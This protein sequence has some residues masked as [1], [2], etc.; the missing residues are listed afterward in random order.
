VPFLPPARERSRQLRLPMA[1]GCQVSRAS[2]CSDTCG[3]SGIFL[4]SCRHARKEVLGCC[5]ENS[6]RKGSKRCG[7]SHN[8]EVETQAGENA[9]VC[10]GIPIK[11]LNRGL[12]AVREPAC[13]PDERSMQ[14]KWSHYL[15]EC[16]PIRKGGV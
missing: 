3:P 6:Q 15:V 12:Y 11:C 7:E 13:Q 1:V 16:C 10:S 5:S 9:S 14:S 8:M 4:P 2:F